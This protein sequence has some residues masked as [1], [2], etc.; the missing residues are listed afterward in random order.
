M[1]WQLIGLALMVVLGGG[2]WGTFRVLKHTHGPLERAFVFRACTV[3]WLGGIL[4][5]TGLFFIPAPWKFGVLIIYLVKIA[6]SALRWHLRKL[7]LR[8][9]DA[10]G[11]I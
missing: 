3:C 9:E 2:V 11:K 5:V 1:N 6:T 7:E 10:A 4:S 8:A